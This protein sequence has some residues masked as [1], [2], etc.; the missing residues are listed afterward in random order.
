MRFRLE[1]GHASSPA[2]SAEDDP[3]ARQ[4]S[5]VRSKHP[6]ESVARPEEAAHVGFELLVD[7][8]TGLAWKSCI[9]PTDAQCSFGL[10]AP[11]VDYPAETYASSITASLSVW[12]LNQ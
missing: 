5:F 6:G 9:H 12:R 3:A 1:G 10:R 8:E 7:L 2:R 4:Q 11:E